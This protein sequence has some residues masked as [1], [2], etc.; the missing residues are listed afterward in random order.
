MRQVN[1]RM[2]EFIDGRLANNGLAQEYIRTRNA[3]G[4]MI[5]AAKAC[6]GIK[7]LTGNNDGPMV[8]LIQRTVDGSAD[9][10]PWCM[11][12]VQTMIGYAEFKTSRRSLLLAT[13][14]CLT[15][16]RDTKKRLPDQMVKDIPLAGAI[17]IWKHGK[18]DNG[19]TEIVL[20][21]DAN[22]FHCVGGN[23]TGVIDP[24]KPVNR[25]GNGVFYTTRSRKGDG[26]MT[27]QGFIKPFGV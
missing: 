8:E 10:E 17:V 7:E 19:H 1:Q 24:T 27:I 4:L 2:V 9:H 14:H 20:D 16:F 22:I 18:T 15:F 12:F 13:E 21:C 6:V 23:T 25:N 26:D 3:R 11:A 5:E